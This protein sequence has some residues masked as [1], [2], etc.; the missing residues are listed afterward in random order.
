MPLMTSQR[1][2][3]SNDM[4]QSTSFEKRRKQKSEGRT[5]MLSDYRQTLLLHNI[6]I[7]G[8]LNNPTT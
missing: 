6:N 3:Y 2:V 5:D 4:F 7:V 1:A 8:T